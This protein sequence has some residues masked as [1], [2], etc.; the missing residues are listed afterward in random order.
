MAKSY[1]SGATSWP[2]MTKPGINPAAKRASSGT[3]LT[4]RDTATPSLSP[5]RPAR[6]TRWTCVSMS[7][8]A[9][10]QMTVL[11]VRTSSPRA[12]TS[13]AT[14][15][16]SLPERKASRTRMR[17]CWS[18]SPCKDTARTPAATKEACTV[19]TRLLWLAKM[20]TSPSSTYADTFCV[21]H[22]AL[23]D[24]DG[25]ITA[26]CRTSALATPSM[27]TVIRTGLVSRSVTKRSI[28]RGRVAV[29]S[30]TWRS[31]RI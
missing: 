25:K 5:A 15:T 2:A 6:P 24:S 28:F 17:A 16:C 23:S 14:R 10:K 31:G 27:P 4:S 13:V 12:R 18:R 3:P 29:K 8:A 30:R 9:S 26:H 7:L 22:W 21:S 20:M 1:K 11:M 19:S